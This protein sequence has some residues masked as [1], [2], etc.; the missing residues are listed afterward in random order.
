MR[1]EQFT[2]IVEDRHKIHFDDVFVS[3]PEVF[4]RL[5]PGRRLPD[6]AWPIRGLVSNEQGLREDHEIP[7]SKAADEVRILFLGDSCTFG[8]GLAHEES[9]VHQTEELLRAALPDL[10][11]DCINA[12][13]PGY[14]AF[15]G[16]RLLETEGFAYRPDLVVLSFGWNELVGWDGISDLEHY[17]EIQAV[18]PP[19]P[20]RGSRL[21]RLLWRALYRSRRS[22]ATTGSRPRLVPHEFR[23]ILE[24]VDAAASRRGV[25]LLLLVWPSSE[26][27]EQDYL[28]PLQQEQYDFSENRPFGPDGAPAR[29]DGVAVAR[30]V[31][32]QHPLAA[33]YQDKLHT[34]AL[35]NRG[36]A[37]A[38][39][40]RIE[41]WLRTRE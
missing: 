32:R 26:N 11:I 33:M 28:T 25:E 4:W 12:G 5:M 16:W 40:D 35:A 24:E 13:V 15:Q 10:R 7:H 34:T 31:A 27:V 29:V 37:E 9:F 22:A 1:L 23:R 19:G 41:P 14:T 36:I 30:A 17:E 2:R 3:D 38:L 21:C 20:L 6:D 39:A 18:S 8:Y